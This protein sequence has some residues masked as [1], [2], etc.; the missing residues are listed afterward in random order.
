[1]AEKYVRI[2]L[3]PLHLQVQAN[4]AVL[5]AGEP[6]DDTTRKA[7]AVLKQINDQL[8]SIECGGMGVNVHFK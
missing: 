7:I 8:S 4:L 1:L 2:E 6:A 3:H 5:Q